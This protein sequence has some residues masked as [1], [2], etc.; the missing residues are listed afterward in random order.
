MEAGLGFAVKKT[1]PD[2]IGREAVLRKQDEGLEKRLLQFRLSDP[3]PLLY[4]AEPILRDGEIVGHLTSGSY[5]HTLG[6]AIGL[7]YVPCKEESAADM[8]ASSYEIEVAG[9]RVEAQASLKPMYD[10]KSER[11]KL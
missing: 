9:I 8:L 11:V 1:K 7:G 2:F 6:G 5:G 4:H 3:D 10:P